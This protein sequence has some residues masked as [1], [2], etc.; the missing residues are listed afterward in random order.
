MRKF[1]NPF[2]NIYR[3]KDLLFNV[4]IP[5][6]IMSV[7]GI[8]MLAPFIWM[9]STSLKEE[10]AVFTYPPEF[11]PK[12]QVVTEYN[13]SRY[14]VFRWTPR[15][16]VFAEY[17]GKKYPVYSMDVDKKKNY[18]IKI[19]V[20]DSTA[21]VLSVISWKSLKISPESAEL[22]DPSFGPEIRKV[23][24][25]LLKSYSVIFSKKDRFFIRLKIFKETADVVPILSWKSFERSSA[26][27]KLV[28]PVFAEEIFQVEGVELVAFK[29]FFVRFKN[30]YDAWKAVPFP[31]F[32]LNSIFVAFCVTFGQLLTCSLAAYA[33]ARLEFPGRDKIFF[34][35]L[36]TMMIPGQVTMIPVFILLKKMNWIDTYQA[37]ILPGLFSAYG[38]FLLRQFFLTIPKDLEDAAVIDGCSKLRIWWTIIIPLSK[39]AIATLATFTFM[40]SWNDFMWP[41][42][43][44]NSMHMKTLPIGLASFQGLYTTNW[45]LLMAASMIVLIPVIVIYIFNQRFFTEGIVL[46]G[47]KG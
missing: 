10:G 36:A 23:D 14:S 12:T 32:Y 39:A 5:Y 46:S 44:T 27:I 19:N 40:G 20:E 4:I 6:L 26:G 33:F 31:R 9:V 34:A 1:Q 15:V 43:V 45:T 2:A 17:D 42:I 16:Q 8:T 35:Y 29:K 30:Y 3:T 11:I 41:L 24:S 25:S 38:T 28:D 37:L 13:K 22:I 7:I 47:L 21:N 18:V